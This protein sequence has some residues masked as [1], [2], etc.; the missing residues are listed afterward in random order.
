MLASFTALLLNTVT[1]G[2]SYTLNTKFH[3]DYSQYWHPKKLLWYL[4]YRG[5]PAKERFQIPLRI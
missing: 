5:Y 3:P 1:H 2:K 4:K